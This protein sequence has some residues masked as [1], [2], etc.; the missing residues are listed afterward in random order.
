MEEEGLIEGDKGGRRGRET[1]TRREKRKKKEDRGD[2][3]GSQ[4]MTVDRGK[5]K[6][7]SSPRVR[8]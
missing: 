5:G 6:A 4:K 7:F 8:T 3:R 2:F 1:S